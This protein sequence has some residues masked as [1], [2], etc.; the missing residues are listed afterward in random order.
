MLHLCATLN[1]QG[2]PGKTS[3]PRTLIFSQPSQQAVHSEH[4]LATFD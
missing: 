2:F 3:W 1:R 4:V